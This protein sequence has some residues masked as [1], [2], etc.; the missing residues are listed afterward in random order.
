MSVDRDPNSILAS[1]VSGFLKAGPVVTILDGGRS[2][3][4]TRKRGSLAAQ[5]DR[6]S[7]ATPAL[8]QSTPGS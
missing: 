4:F 3:A 2:P 7:R 6:P 8:V 1:L 5:T